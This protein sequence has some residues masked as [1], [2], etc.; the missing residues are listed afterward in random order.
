MY[1]WRLGEFTRTRGDMHTRHLAG[2]LIALWLLSGCVAAPVPAFLVLL[3]PPI[4]GIDG[5]C[6]GAAV[7]PT[8][9]VTAAH[10]VPSAWR[11]VTA[12]G[13]EA[14]VVGA[15]VSQEHDIAVLTVDRTLWLSD[16]A[17]FARPELGVE[18]QAWGFCP[19]Q[20]SFVARHAFYNGL[21]TE[22]VEGGATL[23]YGEWILPAIP[24]T[25]N[26]FCGGDSGLPLVQHGKVV[27]ILSAVQSDFFFI[28]LGSR[29][30]TVPVEHAWELLEVEE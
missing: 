16:F 12:T 25:S 7:S 28:A 23:D 21:T 14:R 22:T 30:F 29:A 17:E 8:Q 13:Q 11:V 27:G 1:L 6:T 9:I 3:T 19:W 4:P 10:C 24:G 5:T 2:L 20:V 26:K 18:A 15:V